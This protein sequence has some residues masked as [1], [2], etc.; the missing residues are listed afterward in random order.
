MRAVAGL[1]RWRHN[2]LRRSTDL[3]EAWVALAAL[4]LLLVVAV[5]ALGWAAGARTDAAL[6]RSARL[7]QEQR[8]ATTARV[9]GPAPAGTKA[10]PA[11]GGRAQGAPVEQQVR[12]TVLAR[13]KAPDGKA[14]TGALTTARPTSHPG[15]TFR[16]WTDP[17]GR[18]TGRPLTAGTAREHAVLAGTGAALA[19]AGLV[20]GVRRLVVWRLHRRRYVRL[21]R[22]W[23]AVGPDWGR[24]D[25][26]G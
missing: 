26:G 21:D 11:G 8:H 24:A 18:P 3:T 10:V 1:W 17:A 12:K 23:A 2:S 6:Q 25:A 7:Q 22:A 15:D 19:A 14:R 9:L 16:I 4:L 5:P 20:E 13:W